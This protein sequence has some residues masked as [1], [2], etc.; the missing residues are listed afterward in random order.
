MSNNLASIKYS[1]FDTAPKQPRLKKVDLKVHKEKKK[2]PVFINSKTCN[3]H[4][5]ICRTCSNNYAIIYGTKII[6]NARKTN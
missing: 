4:I 6:Y 1:K 3:K 5:A 2:Q